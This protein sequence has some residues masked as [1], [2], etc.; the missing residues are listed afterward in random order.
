MHMGIN[1]L[2]T[3]MMRPGLLGASP[4]EVWQVGLVSEFNVWRT[5]FGFNKPWGLECLMFQH[6]QPGVV[7]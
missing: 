5:S 3:L 1:I 4:A 2:P 6:V 7:A